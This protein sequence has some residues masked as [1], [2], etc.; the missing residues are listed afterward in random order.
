MAR[1][2]EMRNHYRVFVVVMSV[3]VICL[4]SSFAEFSLLIVVYNV[5][6]KSLRTELCSL[7]ST[8]CCSGLFWGFFFP[9]T[10]MNPDGSFDVLLVCR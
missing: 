2:G 9:L 10:V 8:K 3:K 1:T 5:G 4:V 7:Y 6:V